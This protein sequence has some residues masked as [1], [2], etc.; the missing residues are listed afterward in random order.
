[1]LFTVTRTELVAR[2]GEDRIATLPAAAFP[3]GTARTEG[4]RL[5]H[6]VGAPTG[7]LSLRGPDPESGLLPAYGRW[8]RPAR[9]RAS[10]R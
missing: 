7:T 1:M 10:G 4:A 9:R 8:P 6:T 2:F 3:P 5:L